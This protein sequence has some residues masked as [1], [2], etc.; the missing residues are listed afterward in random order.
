MKWFKFILLA[1]GSV[2]AMLLIFSITN[3]V[4]S[5]LWYLFV[6]GLVPIA[7]FAGYK[8]LTKNGSLQLASRNTAAEIELE[9]S[10]K[11]REKYKR[12][13]ELK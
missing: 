4:Y 11:V 7:G 10:R 8:F 6:I 12:R 3:I 1:I 5:V 2:L 9:N 13:L